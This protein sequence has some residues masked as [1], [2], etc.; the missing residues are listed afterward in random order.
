LE[1][2]GYTIMFILDEPSVPWRQLQNKL[3]IRQMK[4]DFLELP[5]EKV[6]IKFRGIREY[7]RECRKLEYLD[8]PE[9]DLFNHLLGMMF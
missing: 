7:I 3:E 2:L 5:M 9:Y 6:P 4:I 1:G 8:K